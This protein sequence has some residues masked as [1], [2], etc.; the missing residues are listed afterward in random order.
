MSKAFNLNK[1]K[2]KSAK[3]IQHESAVYQVTG[4]AVYV[5]DMKV[6]SELL[7]VTLHTSPHAHARILKTDISKALALPGVHCILGA[8]DIQGDNQMGPAFHDEICIAKDLATFVMQTIFVIGAES[9]EIGR[10]ASELIEIEYEV[11][12]PILSIEDAIENS[13]LLQPERKIETG[14]VDT[15]FAS[16]E[17]ILEGEIKIGG[18]EHWYL[19][20]Q[21]ALTVPGEG[22]EMTVYCGTQNP[23]ETQALVAEVLGVGKMEVVVDMRRMGGAFGGKE[24]QGNHY[25]IWAALVAQATKRPAKL[26]MFR[27]DDQKQTGKR[28]RFL[29]KYKAAYTND[30]MITAVNFDQHTDGGAATDLTMAVLERAMMHCENAYYIP[31]VRVKGY[32]WFLNVPSNTAYRGFGGPQG[33]AAMEDIVDQIARKLKIDSVDVRKKNL[34]GLTERNETP[35]GQVLNQNHLDKIYNELM[36]SSDYRNRRKEIDEFNANN[37]FVKRGLA[38]TPVKFGISFTTAFLNQA[39]ALVHIYTDGT[40]LVSHGGA[41]MGQ[42]LHTKMRQ[43]A[44]LELGIDIRRVKVGSTNTA[45]VPNTSATAASA[46]ADLNGMAI[47]NAVDKLKRRIAEIAAEGFNE[48]SGTQDSIA[49]NIVFENDKV[50]DATTNQ[51]IGFA[52]LMP[53]CNFKQ[54]SL[55]ATGYY[56]TPGIYFDRE[57]G[58]GNPYLYFSYGMAVTEVEVDTLTGFVINR[59]AD[60]HHDVGDSLNPRLDIGQIEGAY[61][62]GTGWCT[63]EELKWD[64]KGNLM[65]HSPDTYKIPGVKDIPR[66][67]RTTLVQDVP[68]PPTI[69]KSKAVAEPPF[70][71]GFS[72]WLA[73]KDA[74]SAVANHKIEPKWE[75]PATNETIL[76]SIDDLRQ[77]LS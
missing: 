56:R 44:A 7:H 31:N 18:Q 49:E 57:I 47:K 19:E 22:E 32:A 2:K 73:I 41:E 29:I 5:D 16:A 21:V 64:E 10:K 51:E 60:I 42:G 54:I 24:T 52:E 40:V 71:H 65:N 48:D 28:H 6:Q 46:G 3:V 55:S 13:R 50:I 15:V 70:I 76:L 4:E 74:I 75:L 23:S 37:E 36:E 35:Y 68:N 1:Y 39:G 17:N 63:S 69:R 9:E 58:K 67:F 8:D 66:D 14:D 45:K 43:V 33:I 25:A 62:Q 20:T 53:V 38:L 26:R 77:K 59:R 34:Y 72:T 11:L 27:D 61:I 30:G 12:K